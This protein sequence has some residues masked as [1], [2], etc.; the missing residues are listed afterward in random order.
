M[1]LDNPYQRSGYRFLQA[2]V[3]K[4]GGGLERLGLFWWFFFSFEDLTSHL[5]SQPLFVFRWHQPAE[6]FVQHN[7]TL[8]GGNLSLS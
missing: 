5:K 3:R 6:A 7:C 4:M 8:L 2:V 1:C